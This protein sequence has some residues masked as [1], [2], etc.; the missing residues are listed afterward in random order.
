MKANQ[1]ARKIATQKGLPRFGFKRK[2]LQGTVYY[3][4]PHAIPAKSGN[5]FTAEN[6]ESLAIRSFVEDAWNHD[7]LQGGNG[8][9]AWGKIKF[10]GVPGTKTVATKGYK[11]PSTQL[12]NHLREIVERLRASKAKHPKMCVFPM[13]VQGHKNLFLVMEAFL[14]NNG[15]SK[16]SKLE[17]HESVVNK[18]NLSE[19]E[20]H[21]TLQKVLNETAELAKVGLIVPQSLAVARDFIALGLDREALLKIAHKQIDTFNKITLKDGT[22]QI[23]AQDIDDLQIAK[24]PQEA[25]KI[26]IKNISEVVLAR[27]PGKEQIVQT[28]VAKLRTQHKL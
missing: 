19:P 18:I 25:W 15:S 11:Y 6:V 4:N 8:I 12:E 13:T 1:R 26:S 2:P 9:I 14:K 23:L 22:T 20:G 24:S 5:Y 16:I 21:S 7:V 27:N 28:L 17:D 10:K 3:T